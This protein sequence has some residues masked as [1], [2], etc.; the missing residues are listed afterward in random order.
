MF[1]DI[2]DLPQCFSSYFHCWSVFLVTK[3]YKKRCNLRF[4]YAVT[5]FCISHQPS[6]SRTSGH[7]FLKN[8]SSEDVKFYVD[9]GEKIIGRLPAIILTQ[10]ENASCSRIG[11]QYFLWDMLSKLPPTRAKFGTVSLPVRHNNI[12]AP[13]WQPNEMHW[14]PQ[15][16]VFC[17]MSYSDNYGFGGH[18]RSYPKI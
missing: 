14:L 9:S 8:R 2:F 17:A 16:G 10:I 11:N 5:L 1:F 18:L 15:G 4:Q 6:F 3:M 12:D 13:L 7:K